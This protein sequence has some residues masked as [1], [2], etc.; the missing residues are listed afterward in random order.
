MKKII[1]SLILVLIFGSN[2]FAN[3]LQFMWQ[4]KNNKWDLQ[5]SVLQIAVISS[6]AVD[7]MQT[8]YAL[9]NGCKEEN[10]ILGE[11][12]NKLKFYTYNIS[13]MTLHTMTSYIL[14]KRYRT[15]FQSV[16]LG[17][18]LG[19]ITSNYCVMGEFKLSF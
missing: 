15:I 12:P 14:P 11:H 9:N 1:I 18:E 19:V 17:I 10:P 5:D 13:V 2:L 3:P 6:I 4:N 7:M 16:Y 8:N